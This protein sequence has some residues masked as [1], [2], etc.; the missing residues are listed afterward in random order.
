MEQV[1]KVCRFCYKGFSTP[2]KQQRYCGSICAYRG[3]NRKAFNSYISD[4]SSNAEEANT[5]SRKLQ[6]WRPEGDTAGLSMD[7]ERYIE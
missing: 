3:K 4:K 5:D 1:K 7:R 2:R 6:R